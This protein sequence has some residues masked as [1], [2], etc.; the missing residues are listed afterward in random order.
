M[1]GNFKIVDYMYNVKDNTLVFSGIDRR[2]KPPQHIQVKIV[3]PH[4]DLL[5]LIMNAYDK[6]YATKAFDIS[7]IGN[8]VE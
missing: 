6:R 3:N 1:A 2:F 8:T 4:R 7:F 5:L